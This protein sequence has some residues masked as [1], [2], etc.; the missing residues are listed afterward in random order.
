MPRYQ[1]LCKCFYDI[2]EETCRSETASQKLLSDLNS[3]RRSLGVSISP[4]L[5]LVNDDGSDMHVHPPSSQEVRPTYEVD[6]LII[7]SSVSMKHKRRPRTKRMQSTIEK[8]TKKKKS[9]DPKNKHTMNH[10]EATNCHVHK[11]IM[12]RILEVNRC[13]NLKFHNRDSCPY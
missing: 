7:H 3:R 9:H 11:S 12:L 8:L 5:M 13:L 6:G 4:T 1:T 10:S 2:A